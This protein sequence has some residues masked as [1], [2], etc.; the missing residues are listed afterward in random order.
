MNDERKPPPFA[1]ERQSARGFAPDRGFVAGTVGAELTQLVQ[2]YPQA[3]APIVRALVVD[4]TARSI[5]V[6]LEAGAD[7][8]LLVR[9]TNG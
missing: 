4:R 1:V 3:G 6:H 5:Q 2:L 9:L 8:T 7:G